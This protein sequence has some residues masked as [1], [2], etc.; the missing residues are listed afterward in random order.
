MSVNSFLI[1]VHVIPFNEEKQLCGYIE[2]AVIPTSTFYINA[3]NVDAKD[4]RIWLS[5]QLFGNKSLSY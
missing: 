1:S 2:V 5:F 4:P 3:H